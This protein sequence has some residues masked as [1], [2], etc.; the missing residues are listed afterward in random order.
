MIR[1]LLVGVTLMLLIVWFMGSQLDKANLAIAALNSNNATL[2]TTAEE[3]KTTIS[4]LEADL[5]KERVINANRT[6]STA[7]RNE[8]TIEKI[9]NVKAK[10]GKGWYGD[11]LPESAVC[12]LTAGD[13]ARSSDQNSLCEKRTTE[14]LVNA[15]SGTEVKNEDHTTLT[16]EL[17]SALDSCNADKADVT[18]WLKADQ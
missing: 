16:L 18:K 17:Q 13:K 6:E 8:I 2:A 10:N 7:N 11:S 4:Q 1:L 14:G 5:I 9:T 3:N 15:D 12:L